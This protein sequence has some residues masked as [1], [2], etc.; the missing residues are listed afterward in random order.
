MPGSMAHDAGMET[1]DLHTHTTASDGSLSP[2][3]LVAAAKQAGLKAVA[4]TDHDTIDGLTE[5][6]AAGRDLGMEV[7]PGVEISVERADSDSGM[8][9]LGL[10]VEPG[11]AEL[12]AFLDRLKQG[13]AERNPK[14]VAK[15]NELGIPVTMEMVQEIS[16]GGQ[17]GRPHLAQALVK[18]GATGSTQEA[19]NRYLGNG[20]KAYVPKFRFQPDEAIAMLRKAGALPVL[21]HPGLLELGKQ[22]LERLITGLKGMGLMG[23][24]AYYSEHRPATTKALVSLAARLDLVVSGGSDFHGAAK[25][26]IALG[27][28]KGGL[29]VPASLLA[30]L[31]Q[32]RDRLR[33]AG[34]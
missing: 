17:V 24:E 26:A 34:R 16:G 6:A 7:I 5:A 19:F 8:H 9:M 12:G 22:A 10:W 25:P 15:L 20:K 23:V 29:A 4:V 32:A 30:G 18:V 3:E 21:A 1:I 14:I 13:R 2:G 11:H 31:A 27:R 33:A 28:G